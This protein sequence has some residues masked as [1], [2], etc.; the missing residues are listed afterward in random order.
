VTG[1]GSRKDILRAEPVSLRVELEP[2][3][4]PCGTFAPTTS[5]YKTKSL[6][7]RIHRGRNYPTRFTTAHISARIFRPGIP[8]SEFERR[9]YKQVGAEGGRRPLAARE[10][11][12]FVASLD[13]KIRR[14]R[15]IGRAAFIHYSFNNFSLSHQ[16]GS[17]PARWFLRSVTSA[18][19]SRGATQP[20]LVSCHG[21]AL[22]LIATIPRPDRTE[23]PRRQRPGFEIT[24]GLA[25]P[26]STPEASRS[27]S[28]AAHRGPSDSVRMARGLAS[29]KTG[30]DADIRW[31]WDQESIAA[32]PRREH[33]LP[34]R[35][36]RR[37]L[38][39][40]VQ[41]MRSVIAIMFAVLVFMPPMPR[42]E[43]GT[44]RGGERSGRVAYS[45]ETETV[46]AGGPL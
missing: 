37:N 26:K 23:S 31:L 8:Q 7:R 27:I 11:H 13:A 38:E 43:A 35:S 12:R 34:H 21:T 3:C 25:I 15:S 5:S 24:N 14:A 6:T 18:Q 40:Q 45:T 32:P 28:R 41:A 1:P 36:D 10:N 46:S 20:S 17:I 16:Q 30:P 33:V 44:W 42:G 2:G 22:R 19:I 9:A 39:F 4:Y 29:S